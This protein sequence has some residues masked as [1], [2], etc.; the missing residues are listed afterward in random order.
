MLASLRGLVTAH[1]ERSLTVDVHGVGFRLF[2]LP[3]TLEQFP[4]GSEA[5]LTTH[6]HVREDAL[7]LY[8]FASA[9]ERRL[10]EK[11]LTVSGVGPRL[12]LGVL[13][14]ASVEDLEAAI[15]RGQAG[16]LTKV[17][18]VGT[19]TAERII[20]DLKGKLVRD[21]A[22]GDSAMGTVIDA[23]VNLGYTSREA[24]EAAATTSPALPIEQRVKQ[25][26]KRVG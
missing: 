15:E 3:R 1:D 19:K 20:V 9:A 4:V 16:L 14:A 17:S 5:A 22:A 7:E 13:S 8:G 26:L 11:L 6:L 12:A 10:F 21:E 2:V 23:L 24:R 25:A 18:G